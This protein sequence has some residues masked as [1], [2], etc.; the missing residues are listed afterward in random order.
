MLSSSVHRC[1]RSSTGLG[2]KEAKAVEWGIF[3]NQVYL[4]GMVN[5]LEVDTD[6]KPM[7]P[8]LSGY[9]TTAP[10]RLERIYAFNFKA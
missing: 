7:I 9:R 4:Y 5:I 2:E 3:A 1:Q 8:L 10:L 6:H